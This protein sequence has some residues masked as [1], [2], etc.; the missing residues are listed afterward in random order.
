MRYQIGKEDI[1]ARAERY[2]R[3]F[4]FRICGTG[5]GASACLLKDKG[6][7]V[8]GADHVFY[9]PMSSYLKQMD[10]PCWKIED[11]KEEDYKKFDLIIV[12]NVV[13]RDSDD[14]R[15]IERLG[16]HFCSFSAAIGAFVLKDREV[17]G[18]AGTHG[19]TTTAYFATQIFEQLGM[20]PGYLIGGAIEGRPSARV[21]KDKYF[22][23]E[24]DEYDSAYF[25]KFSKFHN[26]FIDHLIITS[27]EFDHADIFD[28]IRD[29]EKEFLTIFKGNIKKAF[30]CHEYEELRKMNTG[31]TSTKIFY[32]ENS[33]CG[34]NEIREKAGG[35]IF[36][37]GYGEFS[38]NVVGVKNIENLTSVILFA[39][40]EGFSLGKLSDAVKKM[41]FVKRRQE[42]RGTYK[43][44]IVIDDFA[45]HP[46]AV[47]A[48][49]DVI[50][51]KYPQRAI[52]TILEAASATA[53]SDLFE[54]EFEEALEGVEAALIVS[55]DKPTSVLGAKN[56]NIKKMAFNLERK[57][58]PCHIASKL[59]DILAFI[60]D[61]ANEESLILVMS[62][63][64]CM[65]LWESDFA[66]DIN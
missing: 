66:K 20:N 15:M 14:A 35:S 51:K 7:E 43:G 10:I 27:L 16:I 6:F 25:E 5:M 13:P 9:S 22:F 17:V 2:K 52:K 62:N 23:I 60:G 18:I 57:S 12:G 50:R 58:T 37:V 49:L 8:A 55:V 11:L 36:K 39:L 29:I 34:P 24:A 46:R 21:G 54:R 26:F 56:M 4:F 61:H 31:N 45:H 32:G 42:Y 33:P 41:N 30:L 65:G 48:T 19:K 1:I 53:R 28:S 3:I 44:A 38:T 59:C 63:S 47:R 64:S 40:S